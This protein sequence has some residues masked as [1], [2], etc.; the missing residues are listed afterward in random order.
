[1]VA[2]ILSPHSSLFFFFAGFV[3][4]SLMLED[5][6]SYLILLLCYIYIYKSK[7]LKSD[8]K[9]CTRVDRLFERL[10]SMLIKDEP[11]YE[12]FSPLG[13][14]FNLWPAGNLRVEMKEN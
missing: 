4:L 14:K 3:F 5:N 2:P 1:M 7:V 12:D 8:L 11:E 10:C 13:E 6:L 9:L